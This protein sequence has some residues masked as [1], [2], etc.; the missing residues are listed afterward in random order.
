M[1]KKFIVELEKQQT[2]KQQRIN[3]KDNLKA[4]LEVSVKVLE[5]EVIKKHQILQTKKKSR[6]GFLYNLN[7]NLDQY[8]IIDVEIRKL[9]KEIMAYEDKLVI[10]G[11]MLKELF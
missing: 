4:E 2:E 5:A 11:D 10:R 9:Q 1:F 7:P 6:D 3:A 8:D